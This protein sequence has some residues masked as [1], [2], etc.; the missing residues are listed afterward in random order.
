MNVAWVHEVLIK[1]TNKDKNKSNNK[2]RC[3]TTN[4]DWQK[5]SEVQ[6]LYTTGKQHNKE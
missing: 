2:D 6:G 3:E 4:N 1:E 5:K